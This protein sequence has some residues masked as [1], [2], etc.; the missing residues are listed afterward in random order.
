MFSGSQNHAQIRKHIMHDL[1][2]LASCNYLTTDK[3]I[4]QRKIGKAVILWKIRHI[5]KGAG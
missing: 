1:L 5:Y 2:T 3:I 4:I